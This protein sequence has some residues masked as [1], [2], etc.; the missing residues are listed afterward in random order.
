MAPTHQPQPVCEEQ[1]AIAPRAPCALRKNGQRAVVALMDHAN[2]PIRPDAPDAP[3]ALTEA[4]TPRELLRFITQTG[5]RG[6]DPADP[7]RPPLVEPGS[8]SNDLSEPYPP[9]SRSVP[10]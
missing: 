9:G 7:I 4:E 10:L 1:L 3:D 2:L 5:R 8:A 6:V